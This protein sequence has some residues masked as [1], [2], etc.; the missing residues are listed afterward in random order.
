MLKT[1][2]KGKGLWRNCSGL[3]LLFIFSLLNVSGAADY[4]TK[5]IQ[6][7]V[8]FTPGGGTDVPAR[9][10]VDR[11][12]ALLGQQVIVVNKPGGGGVIGT[13]AVLG[14]PPDGYTIIYIP[15]QSISAPFFV[16]GATYDVLRD[17][18]WVNVSMSVPFFFAVKKDAPWQTFEELIAD[19]KK[20]PGKLTF[21]SPGI[22]STNFFFFESLK[23]EIGVDITNIPMDSE[24]NAVSALLGGHVNFSSSTLSGTGRE[25]LKSGLIR[26]L[27]LVTEKRHKDFPDI[28]TVA[29]RG[30]SNIC[31]STF[32]A[33]GIRVGAPQVIVEKLEKAFKEALK[34]KELIE[35]IE[36]TGMVV[37]NLGLKE[38]T[39]RVAREYQ[40]RLGVARALNIIPK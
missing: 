12:S 3:T 17:F 1:L 9:L 13:Y 37:E 19:A 36:K 38:A 23:K 29:E 24:A 18:I 8:P 20:N 28:P 39:E 33:S 35:R 14:A 30:L 11:V 27:A 5:P 2:R 22:G 31:F 21:S 34:D 16:K 40:R 7:I 15:A 6:M 10:I 25:M 26:A 32:F 4:P